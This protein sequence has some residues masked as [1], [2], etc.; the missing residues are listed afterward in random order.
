MP[1][2]IG[3]SKTRGRRGDQYVEKCH[4]YGCYKPFRGKLR[5]AHLAAH[6]KLVHGVLNEDKVGDAA[7][8]APKVRVIRPTTPVEPALEP[9]GE[10]P[11]NGHRLSEVEVTPKFCHACG[12][13]I[14]KALIIDQ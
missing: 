1:K 3:M 9:T 11:R 13:R 4:V 7:P 8:K 2:V 14:P 10:P 6:L 12:A 5:K